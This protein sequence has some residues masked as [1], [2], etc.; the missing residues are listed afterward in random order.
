M[1]LWQGR[2]RGRVLENR[3]EHELRQQKAWQRKELQGGGSWKFSRGNYVKVARAAR[4]ELFFLGGRHHDANRGS[5]AFSVFCSILFGHQSR[6]I[7]KR[8]KEKEKK[9]AGAP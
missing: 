3:E 1:I 5:L 9:D 6:A 2:I 7:F 8:K 4:E